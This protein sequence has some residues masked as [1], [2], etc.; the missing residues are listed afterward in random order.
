M[1]Q[2]QHC[3]NTSANNGRTASCTSTHAKVFGLNRSNVKANSLTSLI[4]NLEGGLVAA[5]QK[6]LAVE[7]CGVGNAINFSFQSLNFASREERSLAFIV[8]FAD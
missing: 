6:V 3:V 7:L 4:T 2:R 8:P 1:L 5:I